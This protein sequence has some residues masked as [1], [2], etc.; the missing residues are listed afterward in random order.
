M[1]ESPV[2]QAAVQAVPDKEDNK[3][4]NCEPFDWETAFSLATEHKLKRGSLLTTLPTLTKE[5]RISFELR[6]TRYQDNSYAEIG[7]IM[8]G[9][10]RWSLGVHKEKGVYIAI[11]LN[12]EESKRKFF[13]TSKSTLNE[14]TPV[15]IS[16]TRV[17][18]KYL[19]TLII[20]GKTLWTIENTNPRDFS[21]INVFA[22]SNL[23]VAQAGFIR[24]LWISKKIPGN[25]PSK[26]LRFS[27][28]K[29]AE[30][31]H[32]CVRVFAICP[33]RPV[34]TLNPT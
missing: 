2:V 9:G 28:T 31:H 14:W 13:K 8:I 22:S 26:I 25:E 18:S 11:S 33:P 27:Y 5:W 23:S 34:E 1:A 19:F 32:F 10:W 16:Q 17:G 30:K 3:D 15:K 29:M 4:K 7:Q 6:P 20:R 21:D 24:E 12:G